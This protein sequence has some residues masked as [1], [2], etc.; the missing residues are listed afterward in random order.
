MTMLGLQGV[1]LAHI[2][3]EFFLS[4]HVVLQ[5][6]LQITLV[7]RQ[8]DQTMATEIDQLYLS[9]AFCPA[10]EGLAH[11]G[12]IGVTAF[13]SRYNTFGAGKQQAVLECF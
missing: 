7:R 1:N 10:L 5:V 2:L 9:T 12:G 6:T 13:R 4:G 11:G 3:V 8:V